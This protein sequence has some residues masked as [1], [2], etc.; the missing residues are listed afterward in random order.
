MRKG[1]VT[2]AFL[3]SRPYPDDLFCIP[4][5][6]ICEQMGLP[7]ES[8]TKVKKACYGLVD[9]PLE[10]YRS[11]SEFFAKLGLQ[12]CWSDAC[13]WVYVVDGVTKGIISGHVDDFLFSGDETHEGWCQVLKSIQTEYKS[14]NWEEQKFTQCGVQVEQHED[15]S[16]SLSQ[17]KYVEDLK[18]IFS[19]SL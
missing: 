4:C 7:A 14:G 18:Y 15:F 1:D 6:D 5:P 10:W 16:F 11:I 19:A 8:I 17:E 9:A 3:Q 2:G 13:C 12:K